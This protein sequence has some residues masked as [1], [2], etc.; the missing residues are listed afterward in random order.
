[1]AQLGD[2][3]GALDLI[4]EAIA[5][6]E[7]PG[8]EER[9]Y[10]AETLRIKG[11]L[12]VLKGDAAGA[13]RAYIASLDSAR[14]QQAKSWELRT[15]TSYARLLRE[16]GRVAEAYELLAPLYGWFT[17]GFGTMDLKEAKA[18]LDELADAQVL[19]VST[20]LLTS[21]AG[22]ESGKAPGNAGSPA[23]SSDRNSA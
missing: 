17:E 18:L 16:K 9:W 7:R 15:A 21:G 10:Y 23:A 3:C 22:A 13:E 6:V 5:Q 2:L 4:R 20:G 8:Q 1:M 14:Q 19:A 11:W 12:L